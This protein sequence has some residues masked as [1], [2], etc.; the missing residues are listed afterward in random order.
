[1][2][3][4]EADTADE[5]V[6]ITIGETSYFSMP[7]DEID[8]DWVE[9]TI[10][11]GT[12]YALILSYSTVDI[13]D[14]EDYW[15]LYIRST[16]V[17]ADDHIKP[18]Y[19][20]VYYEDEYTSDTAY[21]VMYGVYAIEY[22]TGTTDDAYFRF[23]IRSNF[24][25]VL[26]AAGD[27]PDF[28]G[29]LQVTLVEIDTAFDLGDWTDANTTL[30][31]IAL[32]QDT[33][34][35]G[36]GDL[37]TATGSLSET[38]TSQTFSVTLKAGFHYDIRVES[39]SAGFDDFTVTAAQTDTDVVADM[40]KFVGGT[41]ASS[42]SLLLPTT[43]TVIR[44][45]AGVGDNLGTTLP[46]EEI[47]VTI[48]VSA[49][50]A[51]LL[52]LTA[53]DFTVTVSAADD[54]G[55]NRLTPSSIE[56][57]T[58]E[59]GHLD[60]LGYQSVADPFGDTDWFAVDG[61]FTAGKWYAVTSEV[62][63]GDLLWVNLQAYSDAGIL[64]TET[65][66]FLVFQAAV[67]TEGWI[68]VSTDNVTLDGWA[69][70]DYE[71]TLGEYDSGIVHDAG[72]QNVDGTKQADLITLGGAADRANGKGGADLINGGVGNDTLLGGGGADRLIGGNGHDLL[73]GGGG[74]DTASGGDGKDRLFGGKGNDTLYGGI[75]ADQLFGEDGNDS[76]FGGDGNDRI[77]GGKGRDTA[78]GGDGKDTIFGD[79]GNDDLSGG[80]GNDKLLGGSGS[81]TLAGDAGAD[82]L[83]GQAGDDILRLRFDGDIATGGAGADR[84]VFLAEG[85]TGLATITDF[86]R[87]EGDTID[88]LDFGDL[89]VVD[90]SFLGGGV[91]GLMITDDNQID[92]DLDG[93]GLRD[94]RIEV[95]GDD[96]TLDDLTFRKVMPSSRVR[97]DTAEFTTITDND[98]N[99]DIALYYDYGDGT[100]FTKRAS[101]YAGTNGDDYLEITGPETVFG[102]D[103]DDILYVKVDS[104]FSYG[105]QIVN[106]Y[107]GDGADLFI[108]DSDVGT[109]NIMDFNPEEGDRIAILAEDWP[110]DNPYYGPVIRAEDYAILD[111][112]TTT[113]GTYSG[114]IFAELTL[115]SGDV[116]TYR[117]G[118]DGDATDLLT[119]ETVS[120][121][122]DGVEYTR[123]YISLVG[124]TGSKSGSLG[125]MYP[126]K[127][128]LYIYSDVDLDNA[129]DYDFGDSVYW[130]FI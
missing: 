32:P 102:L 39:L 126:R 65:Q 11:Y 2:A 77:E 66:E 67:S 33:A 24:D 119:G 50:E 61:G 4:G 21:S 110:L 45:T 104:A 115:E 107:G 14:G 52:G 71:V 59:A 70:G 73:K 129:A 80:D 95:A 38:R 78:D 51:E 88:L 46:G 5:A 18:E 13:P 1:M 97:F 49:T 44:A 29:T 120:T 72:K 89:V 62:T 123:F 75:G 128:T 79:A 28:D 87:A 105:T 35:S 100:G 3:D 25:S 101:Y 20:Y 16:F 40:F 114:D 122:G 76:L 8:W 56:I 22:P 92:I 94:Y 6:T 54:H 83:L 106:L 117:T 41:S 9:F 55:D 31:A 23:F 84:F 58:T 125:S 90:D 48:T 7:V 64:T 74:N 121:T 86:T 82:T 91:A 53:A 17:D 68:V 81:D 10:E 99:S 93:D 111:K 98:V 42:E 109:I 15:S 60:D 103:G 27:D 43:E 36:V 96:V 34:A 118:L 69:T 127:T 85:E 47:E 108:I 57:N 37:T 112:G 26:Q 116:V 63:G 30:P 113:T 12:A 124:E 19:G 130:D